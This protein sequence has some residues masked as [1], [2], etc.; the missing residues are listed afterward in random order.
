MRTKLFLAVLNDRIETLFNAANKA[1]ELTLIMAI[2]D[3]YE[4][5]PNIVKAT[6]AIE[7]KDGSISYYDS[8]SVKKKLKKTKEAVKNE[9]PHIPRATHQR[10]IQLAPAPAHTN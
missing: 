3:L 8:E 2:L 4:E 5:E 6:I 9:L 1:L 10:N 7:A